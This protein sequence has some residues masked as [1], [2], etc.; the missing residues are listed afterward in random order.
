[1]DIT[2][3]SVN[4][5]PVVSDIPDQTIDEGETF[6]KINLDGYVAD[7]DNADP[8]IVWSYT[9]NSDL[10][11]SI[12][13]N[14]I[15]TIGIPDVNWNGSETITFEASD[16]EYTDSDDATFTVVSRVLDDFNRPNG[17]L[18][19]NW[20][21]TTWTWYYKIVSEKVD[22]RIGGPLYWRPAS[23]GAAQEAFVTLTKIDSQ[24]LDQLLLKVQGKSWKK[25]AIFVSYG[26]ASRRV[27]IKTYVP[28]KG[29]SVLGSFEAA[30]IDG[31]RL[32]ARALA[33][34]TVEVYQDD[35]LIG[36]ANAGPFFED[37]GGRIG[38]WFYRAWNTEFDDF[39]GGTIP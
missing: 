30:F 39:G 21:G 10:S 22:V 32:G 7:V 27:T 18:G 15:A 33:D 25:G 38:L 29:W 19:P 16:G 6:V 1:V 35:Q 5:A 24:G 26:H 12:D 11:V 36:Q 9:G 20:S 14:R 2:V 28:G 34:G 17:W 37:R 4:D 23:F 3:S 8:E 31:D 13:A